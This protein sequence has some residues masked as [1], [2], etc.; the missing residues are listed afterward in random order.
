VPKRVAVV[1]SERAWRAAP[2]SPWT[3][4]IEVHLE[5]GRVVLAGLGVGDD[6]SAARRRVSDLARALAEALR[7]ECGGDVNDDSS[8]PPEQAL[9][10]VGNAARLAWNLEGDLLVL[11]DLTNLGPKASAGGYRLAALAFAAIAVALW[12]ALALQIPSGGIGALLGTG[13][14]ALVLSIAAYA[15]FEMGRFAGRFASDDMPIAW[16]GNDVVVVA[17]WVSRYGA[18]DTR[19]Q[20]R[21]GAAI[22][23]TEIHGCAA[24]SKDGDTAV[25]LATEHGPIEVVRVADK[26]FGVSLAKTVERA[27]ASVAAP[28]KKKTALQRAKARRGDTA[29]TES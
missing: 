15:F 1:A 9:A 23:T 2:P 25:E 14:V 21:F 26:D 8:A 22:R 19:P 11:R 28:E 3:A 6:E 5:A 20:G 7:V 16:F 18:V 12:V 24:F 10:T 4:E 27:I 29:V 13:S 17:P